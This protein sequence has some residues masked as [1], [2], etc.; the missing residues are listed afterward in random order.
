[1]DCKKETCET[2]ATIPAII[3]KQ[4]SDRKKQSIC[5]PRPGLHLRSAFLWLVVFFHSSGAATSLDS[6]PSPS[7]LLVVL[8]L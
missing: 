4:S 1:M 2:R 3:N 5:R 8:P 6:G 7:P